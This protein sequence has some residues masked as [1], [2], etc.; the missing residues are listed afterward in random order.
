MR[1]RWHRIG[2]GVVATV[3]AALLLPLPVHGRVHSA[4]W[5]TSA[6]ALEDQAAA[7]AGKS[8]ASLAWDVGFDVGSFWLPYISNKGF[9]GLA[10]SSAEYPGGS[11]NSHLWQ[12]GIWL[13][14]Y[15]DT[16]GL[17][18]FNEDP[19]M[20]I[21]T[22]DQFS[23]LNYD[24][25]DEGFQDLS[26]G[27]MRAVRTRFNTAYSQRDPGVTVEWTIRAWD[28]PGYDGFVVFE[29]RLQFE[30]DIEQF[31]FG[32]MSDCDVGNNILG[33]FHIDDLAGFDLESGLA[34]MYD[35]DGDPIYPDRPDGDKVSTTAIGQILLEAPLPGGAVT[36][37]TV[38]APSVSWSGFNWWD[39]NSDV[40]GE[41]DAYERLSSNEKD[42]DLP[43]SGFDYRIQTGVGP[44]SVRAGD[45]AVFV[46]AYVLGDGVTQ[47]A[48]SL[49]SLLENTRDLVDFHNGGY[50]LAGVS[51]PQPVIEDPQISGL[52]AEVL[53][54]ADA[55]TDPGFDHYNLYWSQATAIGPWE[56]LAE[57]PAG[58]RSYEVDLEPGFGQFFL[59]TSESGTGLESNAYSAW[60]KTLTAVEGSVA[61]ASSLSRI[62]VAPNP[63]VG[64][65]DWELVDY[66]GKILFSNLP[67]QCTLR[68]YN[69]AGD[70]VYSVEH[71]DPAIGTESWNLLTYDR[72]SVASG[73]YL[74]SVTAPGL[75]QKVGKFAIIN[76][77]R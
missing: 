63:Y 76:G 48:S 33:D 27:S 73:L 21:G 10:A 53:W 5:E 46:I 41:S 20:A 70:L 50:E 56:L 11:G 34:Y 32:W 12:G 65:A 61:T 67:E 72:Q 14:G 71:N 6:A 2:T 43:V 26:E 9:I 47:A 55:E 74:Y 4:G 30:K 25:I 45:S 75:G 23:F 3:V 7:R 57:L 59:V 19:W 60:S 28:Q 1:D 58:T 39:W 13:G 38:K 77:Q 15:V 68:I 16:T 51:P 64:S 66:E 8:P 29:N 69:L 54:S 24:M 42:I 35:A 49:G 36:G 17:G 31:Y 37:T 52:T 18:L 40:T 44:Y 22:F 62:T